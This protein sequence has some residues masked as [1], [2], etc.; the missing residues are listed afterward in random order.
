[1][2][3]YLSSLLLPK[4]VGALLASVTSKMLSLLMDFFD[5]APAFPHGL[6]QISC[7]VLLGAVL[8]LVLIQVAVILWQRNHDEFGYIMGDTAL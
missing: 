6:F 5:K 4:M 7:P 1:M 3:M 2:L 8:C